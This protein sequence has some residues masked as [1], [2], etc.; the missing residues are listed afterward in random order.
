MIQ[1]CLIGFG[2]GENDT[3]CNLESVHIKFLSVSGRFNLE[4][5]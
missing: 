1:C 2:S 4:S 5:R 3:L